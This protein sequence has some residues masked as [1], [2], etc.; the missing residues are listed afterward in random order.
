M[1]DTER[2]SLLTIALLAAFAAQ[3][4]VTLYGNVD[5]SLESMK[6][7]GQ[8]AQT[9]VTSGAGAPSK[10]GLRGE[11]DLGNGLKAMF[12]L[13]AGFSADT[14]GVSAGNCSGLP[15]TSMTGR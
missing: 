14:G 12:N 6:V 10:W 3:A 2:Q 9:R 13:E 4:Q 11:E 15:N 1:N 8:S 7:T 5:L